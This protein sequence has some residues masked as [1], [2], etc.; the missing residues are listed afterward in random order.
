[1]ASRVQNGSG[2]PRN[3]QLLG[4]SRSAGTSLE[5]DLGFGDLIPTPRLHVMPP[6]CRLETPNG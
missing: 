1:V 2:C 5:H 3:V 6:R 4:L